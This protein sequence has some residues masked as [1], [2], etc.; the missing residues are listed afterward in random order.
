MALVRPDLLFYCNYTHFCSA[1]ELP[2]SL[3]SILLDLAPCALWRRCAV[4]AVFIARIQYCCVSTF[5]L[6]RSLKL[7]SSRNLLSAGTSSG[8]IPASDSSSAAISSAF[9]LRRY[10]CLLSWMEKLQNIHWEWVMWRIFEIN[11]LAQSA[12]LRKLPD[13]ARWKFCIS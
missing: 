5:E 9:F 1:G 4:R 3:S 10:P 13:I 11:Y 6:L 8:A 12:P 2:V 7:I